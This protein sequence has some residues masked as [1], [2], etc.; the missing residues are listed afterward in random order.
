MAHVPPS[1]QSPETE[2]VEALALQACDDVDSLH[3]VQRAYA[4]LEKLI[5]PLDVDDTEEL[6]P[7]RSELSA[8]FRLVNDELQRRI[9]TADA[10]VQSLRAAVGGGGAR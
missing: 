3:V 1:P 8:L 6:S 4:C 10:A 9:E 7:S 2:G 5:D